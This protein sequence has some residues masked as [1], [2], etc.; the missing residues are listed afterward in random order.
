MKKT[1]ICIFTFFIISQIGYCSSLTNKEI[2]IFN[3]KENTMYILETGLYVRNI[4]VSDKEIAEIMPITT[5]SN[6]KNQLFIEA[7]KP[8]VC[9]VV[10][11]T[12]AGIYRIRFITG[13]V[14]QDNKSNLIQ[15]DIPSDYN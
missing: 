14:F 10:L 13:P 9:D 11:T 15:L 12:D 2:N 7:N 8:G 5:I 3:L 4:D 6:D 1:I